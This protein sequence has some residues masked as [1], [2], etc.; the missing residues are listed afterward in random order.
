MVALWLKFGGLDLRVFSRTFRGTRVN[1]KMA[2]YS[3][4]S[5]TRFFNFSL[6]LLF[7]FGCFFVGFP[8]CIIT[9]KK[10]KIIKAPVADRFRHKP[11]SAWLTWIVR[12]FAYA[13]IALLSPSSDQNY[14]GLREWSLLTWTKILC[15]LFLLI[16]QGSIDF[17]SKT[18]VKTPEDLDLSTLKMQLCVFRWRC[19]FL[20]SWHGMVQCLR[21]SWPDLILRI[22]VLARKCHTSTLIGEM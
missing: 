8:R 20:F 16:S 9:E 6:V 19:R 1:T 4:Y 2:E 22:V 11:V 3:S 5:P 21:S 10:V 17:R 14:S 12:Y 13:I 15:Y 7:M 18:L